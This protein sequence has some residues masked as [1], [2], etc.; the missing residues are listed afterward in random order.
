MAELLGGIAAGLQ[1][2]QALSQ[3]S[4]K[5]NHCITTMRKAPEQVRAFHTEI[6]VFTQSLETFHS[7][8]THMLSDLDTISP[9]LL[10]IGKTIKLVMQQSYNVRK[11][12]RNLLKMVRQFTGSLLAR[13]QWLWK[14]KSLAV[15]LNVLNTVKWDLSIVQGNLSLYALW[16]VVKKLKRQDREVPAMVKDKM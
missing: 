5:L 3:L 12:T 2:A 13:F 8:A 1:I 6:T 16:E 11:G 7:V 4:T 15:L 14:Q 9:E 10:Q